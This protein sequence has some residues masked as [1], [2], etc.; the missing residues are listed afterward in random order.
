M[1]RSGCLHLRLCC[2]ALRTLLMLSPQP[3][4]YWH[5]TTRQVPS[6]L[7]PESSPV[8][9]MYVMLSPRRPHLL[10]IARTVESTMGSTTHALT[11]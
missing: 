3:N 4:G 10:P 7:W 11:S 1:G 6:P 9:M 8:F 5:N 2:V